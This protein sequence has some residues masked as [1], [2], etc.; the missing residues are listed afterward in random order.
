[1]E[2]Y[3]NLLIKAMDDL[4]Q[5]NCRC[6]YLIFTG[7]EKINLKFTNTLD[8]YLETIKVSKQR[9]LDAKCYMNSMGR[10]AASPVFEVVEN[11]LILS[12]LCVGNI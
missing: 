4:L 12:G 6:D 3:K 5:S 1:M 2:R 8:A 7:N 10:R 9:K 11:K